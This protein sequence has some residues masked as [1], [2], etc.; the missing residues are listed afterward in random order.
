M[1]TA[2]VMKELNFIIDIS[3]FKPKILEATDHLKDI[4]NKRTDVDSIFDLVTRATANTTKEALADII[5]DL[6]I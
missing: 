2:S 3:H 1:I 6:I 5:T 4:S